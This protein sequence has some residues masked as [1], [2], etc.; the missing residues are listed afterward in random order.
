MRRREFIV[1]AGSAVAAPQ[2][3]PLATRAQ[4]SERVRRIGVLLQAVKSDPESQIRIKAFVKELEQFGW[5]EGR[6]LQL[7]YR[8]AGGNS[9]D[10]RKHAADLVAL[11]PDVLVAAGSAT[12]GALQQSTRTV[13]IV[14]ATV[15]D[16]VGAGFVESLARPGGN[17]TGFAI[18]EYA[19]GA[20]WLELL[21]EISPRTTRVAV[22]RDPSVATG[23]GQFGAIQTAAPSLRMEISPVNMR[24]ASEL[25]RALTAFAQSPNGGLIVSGTP[26]AQLHRNLI[27]TLAARH[28]LPAVYFE[29][30]FVVDGGLISYGADFVD[31]Y[32]RA[33]GYVHRILNGEKPA[34]LPVQAPTKYELVINLKTA[35]ALDLAISPSLLATAVEVIE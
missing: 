9:D 24:D 3:W 6:N 28:K 26:L 31:Q 19:I 13:P 1:Y 23:P 12:V 33:G 15:G 25:G 16:P 27:I 29:R 18:F 10:I 2:I 11:A 14:F 32:R 21:R 20:K 7:D 17:I 34:D 22:L 5:T 30:F 8:W 35:K 4:Q